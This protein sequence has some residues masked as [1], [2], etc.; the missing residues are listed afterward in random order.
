LASRPSSQRGES[1]SR[2]WR[3][4]LSRD[5]SEVYLGTVHQ[6]ETSYCM[7]S[8]N[9]DE[10]L[11]MRRAGRLGMAHQ[12]LGV[13]PALC[14]NLVAPLLGLIRAMQVHSRHF[15]TTPN[16]APLNPEHFQNSRNQRLARF[17]S[18]FGRILLTNRSQFLYKLSALAEMT[19]ELEQNYGSAVETL[20]EGL[21]ARPDRYWD[22]MD[23]SHY[24]LNTCLRESVVILKCFLHVLP[25]DQL[26]E[27]QA[28]LNEHV[29]A[30]P[31]R[32]AV[33]VRHL[34]HRRLTPI[35]GQ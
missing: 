24:D 1:V 33:R 15:G 12:F 30:S 5:E 16:L 8:V 20:E 6:L 23:A 14:Q 18:L 26:A 32:F 21:T 10:A 22:I 31:D 7:F 3:I 27:F 29:V 2:D 19:E 34:A 9:L 17:N 25:D 35:K 11:G 28:S 4:P 13:A